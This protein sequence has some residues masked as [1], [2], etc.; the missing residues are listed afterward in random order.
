MSITRPATPLALKRSSPASSTNLAR[1]E[2]VGSISA[3][4]YKA[5]GAKKSSKYKN[6]WEI[7]DGIKFRSKREA[8]RY[9]DLVKLQ[10]SGVIERLE[11]QPR[12][13]MDI[14][15][16]HVCTYVAD[17]RYVTPGAGTTVEDVKGAK[18]YVY[19]IK[20]KLM[21]ALYSIDVVET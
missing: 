17:F 7:V 12:Y 20:K 4:E 6:K 21:K 3:A 11:R 9:V 10:A 19:T 13:R 16:V 15:G 2:S 14:N 18:T 1:H 5:L 8:R